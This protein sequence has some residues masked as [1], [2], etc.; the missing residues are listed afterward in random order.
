VRDIFNTCM[1]WNEKADLI[2]EDDIS[3][4]LNS[5]DEA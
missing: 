5:F 1:E 3:G 4:D 2:T